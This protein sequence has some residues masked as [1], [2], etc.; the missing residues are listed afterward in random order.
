LYDDNYATCFNT[1]VT[2][3]IYCTQIQNEE[4]TNLLGIKSTETCIIKKKS[5]TDKNNIIF[6]N[7]WFY[8]SKDL[9]ISKDCRRH[10]DFLAD[11]FLP[12]KD[13]LKLLIN[14]GSDIDLTC[15][16]CSENGQGGPTL[17]QQQ[18]TKLAELGID[19]WFDLY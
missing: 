9:V 12:I 16:W 15:F 14:E 18:L 7:G 10:I 19:F 3:R 4:I 8:S 2:I 6:V 11:A 17:S 13:K 1:Y 5:D